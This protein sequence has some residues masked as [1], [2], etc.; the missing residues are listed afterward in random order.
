MQTT[1]NK[2]ERKEQ[3]EFL[4]ILFPDYYAPRHDVFVARYNEISEKRALDAYMKNR[5]IK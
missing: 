2:A 3:K 4:K 5:G 1:F